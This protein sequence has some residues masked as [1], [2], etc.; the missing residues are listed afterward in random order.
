MKRL[1]FL[2]IDGVLNND[3]SL[4]E[5]I[6]L[7]NDK[8]VMLRV[9]C[10]EVDCEIVIS[11][12]WRILHSLQEMKEI[13]Y[14]AGFCCRTRIIDVTPRTRQSDPD[15]LKKG[16]A[17][18]YEIEKWLQEQNEDYNYVILDDTSDMLDYQKSRFVHVDG[19]IGLTTRNINE[20]REIFLG[21]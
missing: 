21:G 4:A 2:D 9:F 8:L 3:A 5:G 7:I 13:L 16:W 6:H 12:T 1:L 20:M 18:G 10:E 17:R 11:S 14:R 15:F 19:A